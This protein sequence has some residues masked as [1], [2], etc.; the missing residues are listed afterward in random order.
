MEILL[1]TRQNVKCNFSSFV[2]VWPSLSNG[3]P[4]HKYELF[5]IGFFTS[6]FLAKN[7]YINSASREG[8]SFITGSKHNQAT[9]QKLERDSG[10]QNPRSSAYVKK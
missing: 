5:L 9:F 6:M 7:D 10:S 8:P 4:M 1:K 3:S 2:I